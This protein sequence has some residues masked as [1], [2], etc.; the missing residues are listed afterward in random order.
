MTVDEFHALTL[1]GRDRFNAE[2]LDGI[3]YV[4]GRAVDLDAFHGAMSLLNR[5]PGQR[6]YAVIFERGAN[7]VGASVPD[8][9]GCV[10][11][12]A[13]MEEA[14][15]LIGKAVARHLSELRASGREMPEPAHTVEYVHVQ[16]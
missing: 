5:T 4:G 3:P 7:S 8:L 13:S 11:T 16:S 2:L 14:R 10:A 15:K 12:G 6:G 1:D 9:P